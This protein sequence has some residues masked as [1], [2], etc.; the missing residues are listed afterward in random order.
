[1]SDQMRD[2]APGT[3]R[4][5]DEVLLGDGPDPELLVRYAQDPDGLSSTERATIE[6]QLAASPALADELRVLRGFDPASATPQQD[7]LGP[8]SSLRERLRR[9]FSGGPLPVWA[10]VSV[11]AV[12]VA[13]LALPLFF[14]RTPLR[15]REDVK[16]ARASTSEA[17]AAGAAQ[18]L[19]EQRTVLRDEPA[20]VERKVV[21]LDASSA[22]VAEP[23]APPLAA[24]AAAKRVPERSD[25]ETAATVVEPGA[26]ATLAQSG[27]HL[28]RASADALL[29]SPPAEV[30]GE[31]AEPRYRAPFPPAPRR[32]QTS[33]ASEDTRAARPIVLAPEHVARTA[34][35]QPLLLWYAPSGLAS[36]QLV[37]Q[38]PA[39]EEPLL[40]VEL[41]APARAGIQSVDLA[42]L[43]VALAPR[44]EYRWSI[45]GATGPDAASRMGWVRH[46]PAVRLQ[47]DFAQLPAGERAAAWARAGYWHD[48]LRELERARRA[49]PGSEAPRRA[50]ARLLESIGL[51]EIDTSSW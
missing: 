44:T 33:A 47:E 20:Q 19:E 2:D 4:L 28:A 35:P 22:T 36:G 39:A 7:S 46:V 43:G 13:A 10:P 48:A 27:E 3:D 12:L 37:I 17:D 32:R 38:D 26:A 16:L 30:F 15:E 49:D 31:L 41:R 25:P 45:S 29:A 18:A 40:D 51:P 1:M 50:L 6:R 21:P 14:S 5:L 8:A 11:V 42:T 24:E 34:E 9:W 23:A